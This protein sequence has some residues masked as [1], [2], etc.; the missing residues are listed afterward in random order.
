[1]QN[2]EGNTLCHHMSR[3]QDLDGLRLLLN[4][5][6]MVNIQNKDGNTP[7]HILYDWFHD[8]SLGSEIAFLLLKNGA[9]L[10]SL[11]NSIGQTAYECFKCLPETRH[12]DRVRRIHLHIVLLFIIK[13]VG[14]QREIHI[15]REIV[16]LLFSML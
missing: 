1:M 15:P 2:R 7:L 8:G 3:C 5:G 4:Y 13:C 10:L 11:Q 16:R 6:G 14:Q 12:S 9:L